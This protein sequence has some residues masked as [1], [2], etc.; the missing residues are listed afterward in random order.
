MPDSQASEDE[1]DMQTE[2]EDDDYDDEADPFGS[3]DDQISNG[4]NPVQAAKYSETTPAIRNR[5][6]T[7]LRTAKEAGFKV[8]CLRG[9]LEGHSCFVSISIRIAKL[10][11]SESAMQAWQVDAADYLI[12]LIQYPSYKTMEQLIGSATPASYPNMRVGSSKRYKPTLDQALEAFA[13]FN[14]KS[15]PE[16]N[17]APRSDTGFRPTII[18]KSLQNLLNERFINI[19]K[20]R[21]IGMS[22]SGAEQFYGDNLGVRSISSNTIE[23]H[24]F[25]PEAPNKTYPDIVNADHWAEKRSGQASFPLL[26]MQ[27]LLKHFVRCTEFC[28]V[29]HQKIDSD[30]EA[31]KPY[32]CENGLCLFQYVTMGNV[33]H[34]LSSDI[35]YYY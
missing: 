23:D 3:F 8:G 17:T 2:D 9:L 6:R 34:H 32:V 1:Y 19:L 12:L 28:V 4:A 16:N 22:R 33:Y 24:Y 20:Y 21:D 27:M 11:I 18:S 13:V 5:I 7:D 30:I 26:A 35:N 14:P 31:I 10:G 15:T 25:K 29:C